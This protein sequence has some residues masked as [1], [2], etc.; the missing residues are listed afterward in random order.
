MNRQGFT[1]VEG[2]VIVAIVLT[3]GFVF[4]SAF[5]DFSQQQACVQLCQDRGE[6]AQWIQEYLSRGTCTCVRADGTMVVPVGDEQE[7]SD[8]R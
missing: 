7:A 8:G 1:L 6:T 3:L 5:L 4:Y 2:L